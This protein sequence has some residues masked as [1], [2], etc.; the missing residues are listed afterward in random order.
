MLTGQ[1]AIITGASRGIGE[2]ILSALAKTGATV[3]GT[4]T[5]AKGAETISEAIAE[6]GGNLL[7]G[8]DRQVDRAAAKAD[9]EGRHQGEPPGI[10]AVDSRPIENSGHSLASAAVARYRIENMDCPTEEGLIRQK[11]SGMAGIKGLEFNL[12]QRKLTVNHTLPSTESIV[13]ALMDIGL[14]PSESATLGQGGTQ[15]SVYRIENMDCPTEEGL[16]R[17]ALEGMPGVKALDFN[18]MGRT[19]TVSHE[20]AA[21]APVTTAILNAPEAD[22]QVA[23]AQVPQ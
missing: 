14:P 3:V 11:L 9:A 7:Q 13:Q 2:G 8:N 16:L 20:L 1:V 17:K 18:L 5:S 12:M 10:G 21:L 23:S 22:G 6:L 15:Q 19:L 4:A